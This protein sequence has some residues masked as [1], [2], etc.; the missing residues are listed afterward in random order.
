MTQ[1]GRQ[2]IRVYVVDKHDKLLPGDETNH[3][4]L[5]TDKLSE[6]YECSVVAGIQSTYNVIVFR[7]ESERGEVNTSQTVYLRDGFCSCDNCRK[8][9]VP[10][11][12]LT[13]RYCLRF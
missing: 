6:N 13:R 1:T 3:N 12:F 8:A 10:E 4:Y 2:H 5:V 11:N 9:T 7:K